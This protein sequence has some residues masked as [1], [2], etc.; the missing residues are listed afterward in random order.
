MDARPAP[1]YAGGMKTEDLLRYEKMY[2]A[3]RQALHTCW[4]ELQLV[5]SQADEA[6]PCAWRQGPEEDRE[7]TIFKPSAQRSGRWQSGRQ[8]A[9]AWSG[10]PALAWRREDPLPRGV[11][12]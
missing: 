4:L 6:G 5:G 11:D 8:A 2:A 1:Q 3:M 7:R 10:R 12:H 9:P